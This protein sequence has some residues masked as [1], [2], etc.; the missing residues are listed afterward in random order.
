[1]MQAT[2]QTHWQARELIA[3]TAFA[4]LVV[5]CLPILGALALFARPVLLGI[6]GLL[7]VGV[8]ARLCFQG[9]VERWQQAREHRHDYRG[10]KLPDAVALDTGHS[11]AS[12][13]D[14]TIVG[15]DDYVQ[16]VLGPIEQIDLPSTGV[17]VDRGQ[18]LFCLRHGARS[19][20]L[21]APVSGTI[22]GINERVREHPEII[23]AHPF[24]EGW[25]V[26]IRSENLSDDR[27]HLMIGRKAVEWTRKEVDYLLRALSQ[28]D[29]AE[30]YARID[31]S[32]WN[33]IRRSLGGRSAA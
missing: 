11:W 7:I 18:K 4:L 21:P 9:H 33:V 8:A 17:H 23:N 16:Q 30:L 2:T 3:P 31:D 27:R 22:V 10:M 19:I 14:E 24:E 12:L 5:A 20:D 26:R 6:A 1:M 13:A 32:A 29:G 15:A 28:G 25:V